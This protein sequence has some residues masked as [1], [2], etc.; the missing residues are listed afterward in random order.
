MLGVNTAVLG[1]NFFVWKVV[2]SRPLHAW[3]EAEGVGQL[4]GCCALRGLT[5]F[6]KGCCTLWHASCVSDVSPETACGAEGLGLRF[7]RFVKGCMHAC[8]SLSGYIVS[9]TCGQERVQILI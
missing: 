6:G 4:C 8:E 2:C 9:C 7:V 3:L 1:L 5:D